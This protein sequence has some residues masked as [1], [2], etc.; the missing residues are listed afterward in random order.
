MNSSCNLFKSQYK[1]AKETLDILLVQKAEINLKLQSN[2][3]SAV[4]HKELRTVNMD[5]K[6][7]ENEMEHAAFRL[8]EFQ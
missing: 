4:L 5:I 7:T 1:K 8:Q 6:I 3:S 2:V